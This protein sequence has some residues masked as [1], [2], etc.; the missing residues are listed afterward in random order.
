M[1]AQPHHQAKGETQ[2]ARGG[3]NPYVN[4]EGTTVGM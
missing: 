1:L 2:H 3:F 4:N